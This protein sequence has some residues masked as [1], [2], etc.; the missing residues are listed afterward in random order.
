MKLI[1]SLSTILV[2]LL[3]KGSSLQAY[4]YKVGT[5]NI[6]FTDPELPLDFFKCP[7]FNIIQFYIKLYL[8]FYS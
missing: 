1:Q 2:S 8:I 7:K 6:F 4:I 3:T 5:C